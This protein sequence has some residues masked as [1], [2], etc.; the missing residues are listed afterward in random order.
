MRILTKAIILKIARQQIPREAET[1][2]NT[3]IAI[4]YDHGNLD[5]LQNPDW[6]KV[7]YKIVSSVNWLLPK[8]LKCKYMF[9][10]TRSW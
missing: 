1:G 3:I 4:S 9:K 5:C 8:K 2:L 6:G 7:Q 10:L